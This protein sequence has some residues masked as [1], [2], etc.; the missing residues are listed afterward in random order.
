MEKLAAT[1]NVQTIEIKVL[2]SMFS[3]IVL[4]LFFHKLPLRK[5]SPN[6][7]K[8]KLVRGL[9]TGILG[10]FFIWFIY[11]TT[12]MLL[13]ILFGFLF[14]YLSTFSKGLKSY[15]LI[16]GM[17]FS[18]LFLCHLHRYIY[19]WDNPNYYGMGFIMMVLVPRIMY[20]NQFIY[21]RHLLKT[22]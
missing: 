17:S 7:K 9:Y 13:I 11:S 4:V 14:Y 10:L 8:D 3:S 5:D 12:E 20:F 16:N 15:F 18:V 2:F 6:F 22:K 21:Q 1:L 19:Y